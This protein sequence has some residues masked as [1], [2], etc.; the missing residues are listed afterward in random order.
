MVLDAAENVAH[1]P[2]LGSGAGGGFATLHV[3]AF[4]M[5]LTSDIGADRAAGDGAADGGHVMAAAAADLVAENAADHRADH[6]AA[7]VR[8]VTLDH[9]LALDPATLVR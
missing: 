5:A 2:I 9:L 1:V 3:A 7:Y 8:P 6:R 4:H